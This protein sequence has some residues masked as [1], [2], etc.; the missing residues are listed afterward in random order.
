MNGLRINKDRRI[1]LDVFR[2][3]PTPCA[4]K[5]ES[6]DSGANKESLSTH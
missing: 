2:C 3:V 4:S 6:S 1:V 5:D